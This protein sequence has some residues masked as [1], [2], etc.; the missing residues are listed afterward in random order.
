M[1]LF[2]G[3]LLSAAVAVDAFPLLD[4][5]QKRQGLANIAGGF[6]AAV[7]STKAK[8]AT[9]PFQVIKAKSE[10]FENATREKFVFGP[11]TLQ[12]SQVRKTIA[13]RFYMLIHE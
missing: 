4:R 7:A 13:M 1:K 12:P 6:F 11:Y 9:S 10:L 3:I 5:L 2:I 8:N